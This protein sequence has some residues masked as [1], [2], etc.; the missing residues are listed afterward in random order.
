MKKS[1]RLYKNR[2]VRYTETETGFE[3]YYNLGE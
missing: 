1:K 3:Y 2:N